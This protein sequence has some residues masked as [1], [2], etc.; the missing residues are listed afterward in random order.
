MSFCLY[1]VSLRFQ[2]IVCFNANQYEDAIQ[3]VQELADTCPKVD[4]LACH[5]VEVSIVHLSNSR[6]LTLNLCILG[7]STWNRRLGWRL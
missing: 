6:S 3:R 4:T 2:A 5:I 7:V 1:L